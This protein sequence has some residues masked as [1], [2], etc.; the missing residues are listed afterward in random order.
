MKSLP[1]ILLVLGTALGLN[2]QTT[3]FIHYTF[4]DANTSTTTATNSG[5][6]GAALN[7]VFVNSAGTPTAL[8]NVTGV[9]GKAGDYAFNNSAATMSG[10]G[11]AVTASNLRDALS[12]A[13][14]TTLVESYTISM[15]YYSTDVAL[16]NSARLMAIT[17]T[18]NPVDIRN[19]ISDGR[20]ATTLGEETPN[21][22]SGVST[23]YAAVGEWL[24]IAVTVD[25]T[26]P[27]SNVKFYAGSTEDAVS[28]VAT[29]SVGASNMNI[30]STLR[31]GNYIGTLSNAFEGYIDDFQLHLSTTNASGVLSQ[32]QL[33]NIRASAIPE[34]RES[35]LIFLFGGALV[36]FFYKRAFC[37]R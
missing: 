13:Y 32:A 30:S 23:P 29:S 2:A 9:S 10:A 24:Y 11:G 12:N 26:Q 6:S 19:Y 1:S 20:V 8:Q 35:A 25:L 14:G 33:E 22:G 15:W 3:P 21:T 37:R 5:S 17:G 4:N 28:L 7:G 18:A 36:A 27:S 31:I 34:P 16:S